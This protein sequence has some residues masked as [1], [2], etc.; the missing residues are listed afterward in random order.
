MK[1]RLNLLFTSLLVVAPSTFF[2]CSEPEEDKPAPVQVIK[3][4][5]PVAGATFKVTDNVTIIA[6][7]DYSKF[8]S[9]VRVNFSLDTGKTWEFMADKVKKDGITKDTL[10]WSFNTEMP[11][12]VLPGAKVMFQVSE[13]NKKYFQNSPLVTFTN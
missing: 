3:I 7:S 9:G 11:G 6:E 10:V 1:H 13:Y 5:S 8:A 4:L 2:A 12:V